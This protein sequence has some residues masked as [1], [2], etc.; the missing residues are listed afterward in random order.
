VIAESGTVDIDDSSSNFNSIFGDINSMFE[1]HG[2]SSAIETNDSHVAYQHTNASAGPT[3][4]IASEDRFAKS[5]TLNFGSRLTKI[6][7]AA[8]LHSPTKMHK[9]HHIS[10]TVN[11]AG[12]LLCPQT[13]HWKQLL[14]VQKTGRRA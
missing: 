11:L 2:V 6:L 1:E 10:I 5:Y 8:T 12:N 4:P 7:R 14:M 3:E 13:P 9:D